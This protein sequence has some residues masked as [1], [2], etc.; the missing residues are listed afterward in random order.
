MLPSAWEPTP[1]LVAS[2]HSDTEDLDSEEAR[3]C[4]TLFSLLTETKKLYRDV[5]QYSSASRVVDL[6]ALHPKHAAAAGGKVWMARRETLAAQV[7]ARRQEGEQLG[8]R[9]QWLRDRVRLLGNL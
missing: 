5:M 1:L 6:S 3:P 8:R 9:V 4:A 7:L 2:C